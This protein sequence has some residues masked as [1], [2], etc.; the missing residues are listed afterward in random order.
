M[1]STVERIAVL[2]MAVILG[3]ATAPKATTAKA[4]S[5]QLAQKFHRVES[6]GAVGLAA[7]EL[8][9]E[10]GQVDHVVTLKLN[11]Q[12][13]NCYSLSTPLARA[14]CERILKEL[15]EDAPAE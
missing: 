9:C 12:R 5:P 3:C 2:A 4:P 11:V 1:K 7:S 14:Q 8:S 13:P 10:P 15:P 6:K